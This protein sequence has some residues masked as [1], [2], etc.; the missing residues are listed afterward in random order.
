MFLL[1]ATL[2]ALGF[3]GAAACL[4]RAFWLYDQEEI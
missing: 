2:T 3:L 4:L 1:V